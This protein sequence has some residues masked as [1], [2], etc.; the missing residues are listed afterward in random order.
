MFCDQQRKS[1]NKTVYTLHKITINDA[2]ELVKKAT[3]IKNDKQLF[4]PIR[5][6]IYTDKIIS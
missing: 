5:T 2:V 1:V 4:L 3:E 6:C